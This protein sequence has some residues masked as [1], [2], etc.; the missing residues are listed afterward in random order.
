MILDTI[1][2]KKLRFNLKY[3]LIFILIVLIIFVLLNNYKKIYKKKEGFSST[4]GTVTDTS[5]INFT[6]GRFIVSSK[7]LADEIDRLREESKKIDGVNKDNLNKY[8]NDLK[9]IQN[10]FKDNDGFL[11]QIQ[12]IQENITTKLTEYLNEDRFQIVDDSETGKEYI[13]IVS[14]DVINSSCRT[15]K[16][17][18]IFNKC[19]SVC[20]QTCIDNDMCYGYNYTTDSD[21]SDSDNN[22]YCELVISKREKND[23]EKSELSNT[24]F[25]KKIGA[26]PHNWNYTVYNRK[27][28]NPNVISIETLELIDSDNIIKCSNK[29]DAYNDI[30]NKYCLS[31]TYGAIAKE[32]SS[33]GEEFV[34][35][36]KL[37]SNVFKRGDSETNNIIDNDRTN[38]YVRNYHDLADTSKK[39]SVMVNYEPDTPKKIIKEGNIRLKLKDDNLPFKYSTYVKD[40]DLQTNN[41]ELFGSSKSKDIINLEIF[42][43]TIYDDD[44]DDLNNIYKNVNPL[45]NIQNSTDINLDFNKLLHKNSIIR[46]KTNEN[47]IANSWPQ[48]IHC[49]YKWGKKIKYF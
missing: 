24:K 16:G 40:R 26:N 37:Y 9:K 2:T 22:N 3:L 46:L 15:N 8:I 14:N 45:N 39:L 11:K 27:S 35:G 13:G 41:H 31:F 29:C 19:K 34:R 20:Q 48:D 7:D 4:S 47:I 23:T 36:C 33:N 6:T 18:S 12:N 28:A 21:T 5:G 10:Q 32:D 1:I 49:G 17:E 44:D 30:K 42:S 38:L 25:F 43:N